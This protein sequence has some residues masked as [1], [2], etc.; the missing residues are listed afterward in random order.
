MI[1]F[2]DDVFFIQPVIM[3]LQPIVKMV[4]VG[5]CG[6][7]VVQH[8]YN[9]EV[10]GVSYAICNT[11]RKALF[12]ST[13]PIKIQLGDGLG[14]GGNPEV[15]KKEAEA[16]A[17]QLRDLFDDGTQMAFITAGMGKG[18]GTGAAPFV[19]GLAKTSGILTVAFVCL[20]PDFDGEEKRSIALQG[21][22]NMRK[23][24]DAILVVDTQRIFD[25]YQ[26]M[27][28]DDA[29]DRA[30]D[31]MADAAKAIADIVNYCG[32]I[33]VDMEDV[34]TVLKDSGD[35]VMGLG[36]ASGDNRAVEAVVNALDSPL[37]LQS[38]LSGA[39]AMLLNVMYSSKKKLMTDELNSIFSF[40]RM[41]KGVDKS[42]KIIYGL[43]TNDSLEDDLCV[44]ILAT[45]LKPELQRKRVFVSE[46]EPEANHERVFSLDDYDMT[47]EEA[48]TPAYM[49][50]GYY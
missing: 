5:G 11:D 14:A 4:G 22:E 43:M 50:K 24:V 19:A 29:F 48:N 2:D 31:I 7:N 32:T 36:R 16:S 8:V 3:D 15:G 20:P 13:I 9:Q 41:K 21:V 39:K 37:L 45:G 25:L 17:S 26:G 30:N 42:T 18:T 1:S 23:N 10:D 33:D 46:E 47:E 34:R 49:Y 38:E 44:T 40:L 27:P 28:I 35:V 12:R 6:G